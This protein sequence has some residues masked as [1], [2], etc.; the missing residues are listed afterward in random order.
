MHHAIFEKG[1]FRK[2]DTLRRCRQPNREV[3]N[4]IIMEDAYIDC[5]RRITDS[6]IGRKVKILGHEQ[7][8]PRGHKL[9][10]GD[11]AKVTL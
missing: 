2:Q 1:H 8:I 6:L 10:P 5:G 3:E 7:N 4:T 9:I 11:M